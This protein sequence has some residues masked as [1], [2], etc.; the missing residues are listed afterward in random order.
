MEKL[1]WKYDKKYKQWWV[2]ESIPY[3]NNGM[4]I[5]KGET[6][7]ILQFD[8]INASLTF[9]NISSAKKVAQLIVNH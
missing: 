5:T 3:A 7:Y 4:T 1:K 9:K 2:N 6:L 8:H